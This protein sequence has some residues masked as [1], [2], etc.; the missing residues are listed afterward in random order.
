[1]ESEKFRFIERRSM[2]SLIN[3]I[4]WTPEIAYKHFMSNTDDCIYIVEDDALVGIVAA[5]DLQKFY[6]SGGET[7]CINSRFSC[8][9]DIDFGKA[10]KLLL[11]F[12]NIHEIPVIKNGSFLGV[13][14]NGVH[15]TEQDWLNIRRDT[16]RFRFGGVEWRKKEILKLLG[17]VRP[18][19]YVYPILDKMKLTWSIEDWEKLKDKE[20]NNESLEMQEDEWRDFW[21][22][23]YSEDYIRTFKEERSKLKVI[24][25]NGV[26]RWEDTYGYHFNISNGYRKVSDNTGKSTKRIYFLGACT[27][28][29]TFVSEKQTIE[30]YLYKTMETSH[31]LDYDI[32][33]CGLPGSEYFN[34]LVTEQLSENDI[35]IIL[36]EFG[37]YQIWKDISTEYS[38]VKMGSDLVEAYNG[39]DNPA[40]NV[41]DNLYHCN[42]I[43]NER[44]ADIIFH[45]I[46]FELEQSDNREGRRLP[47]LQDYYI[48]WDIVQYYREFKEE[49]N[50]QK[51]DANCRTGAIVMNCNPFTKGHRYLIEYACS[52]V[53]KLYVFVVQEDASQFSFEDRFQMVKNGTTDLVKVCVLPSGKYIIS[54]ETF[55]QYFDKD[56][57]TEVQDMD[58]DLHIFADVVAEE[59]GISVRFIGEEPFDIVTRK[60]N[61]TMKRIL[62]QS[63]V[64]VTE[65]P[66]L[67]N[68]EQEIVSASLARKYINEKSYNKLSSYLPESTIEYLQKSI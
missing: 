32:L 3:K 63:G 62:P 37:E 15:K 43:I 27:I 64:E 6:Y 29:G 2:K 25:N 48:P 18:S 53:D 22:E 44:M 34:R 14:N 39:L 55:E 54:K 19:I 60:Y 16:K 58:Y 30:Y 12:G 67:K 10:E 26:R 24:S 20:K 66:R 42:H 46:K 13:I 11:K 65:I 17:Y 61:E 33:N 52:K 41:I 5:S 56:S 36:S 38:N 21:G 28:F 59:F 45:D 4:E 23:Y 51:T 68:K 47:P 1:M 35:V 31:M 8:I 57:V 7:D 9:D 50:I 40:G 49:R